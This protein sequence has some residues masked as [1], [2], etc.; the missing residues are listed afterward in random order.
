MM[1]PS[2]SSRS[3]ARWLTT[4]LA[5]SCVLSTAQAQYY[6]IGTKGIHDSGGNVVVVGTKGLTER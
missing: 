5:T 2:K 6:K 3:P 1:A 4:L